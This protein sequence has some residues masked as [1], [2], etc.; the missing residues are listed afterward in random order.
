MVTDWEKADADDFYFQ[1]DWLLK[2][3]GKTKREAQQIRKQARNG[4]LFEAYEV[5]AVSYL[6][7]SQMDS[8]KVFIDKD[9]EVIVRGESAVIGNKHEQVFNIGGY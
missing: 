4:E 3:Q 7:Y 2:A 9:G 5:S 1:Y 8:E 6:E